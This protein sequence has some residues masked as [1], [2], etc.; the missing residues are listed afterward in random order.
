M[1]RPSAGVVRTLEIEVAQERAKREVAERM[2][3]RLLDALTKAIGPMHA[4]AALAVPLSPAERVPL[5]PADEEA[6]HA[7]TARVRQECERWGDTPR[8]RSINLTRA[9]ELARKGLKEEEII[10]AIR[11]GESAE[12]VTR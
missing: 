7:V 8:Q 4:G 9:Y 5:P 12:A 10:R 1:G 11:R 6:M 2:V 3:E